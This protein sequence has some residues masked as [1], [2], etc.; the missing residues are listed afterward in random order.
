LYKLKEKPPLVVYHATES[1][2]YYGSFDPEFNRHARDWIDIVVFPEENRAAIDVGRCG[3]QR[4]PVAIAYNSPTRISDLKEPAA[5]SARNGRILYS[6][7][8]DVNATFVDYYSDRR[9]QAL[10]ID[11]YGY[12]G[13]SEPDRT[14]HVLENLRGS[15]RYKGFVDSSELETAR[16]SYAYSLTIWKASNE[17]QTYACPCK[18]YESIACGVPP[19]TA[20]HPQP[21]QIVERYRCGFVMSDWSLDAMVAS[22]TEAMRAYGT[23]EYERM[24]A[25]CLAAMRHELNWDRQFERVARLLPERLTS[26]K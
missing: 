13:G 7:A 23:P 11:I 9:L 5:A 2:T 26:R 14:R 6:G 8:L 3:F 17:N 12:I 4:I 16:P 25:N 18:F 21:K 20:P 24:V 19:I 1:T 22:F 10:P 15:I